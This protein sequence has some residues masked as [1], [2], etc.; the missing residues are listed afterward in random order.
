[1]R[2]RYYENLVVFFDIFFGFLLMFMASFAYFLGFPVNINTLP[3]YFIVLFSIFSLTVIIYIAYRLICKT[4][5]LFTNEGIVKEKNGTTNVLIKYIDIIRLTY[6][7]IFTLLIGDA[8]GGNLVIDFLN[9]NNELSYI[10]LPISNR[11][12]QLLKKR[13][14]IK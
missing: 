10:Y 2:I 8:K 14:Y 11:N 5:I 7:N 6:Y 12:L 9:K 1:M 13:G 4:Y 3:Y